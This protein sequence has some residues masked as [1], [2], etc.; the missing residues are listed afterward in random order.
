MASKAQLPTDAREKKHVSGALKF[1]VGDEERAQALK[2]AA[3]WKA[4]FS[5]EAKWKDIVAK[6]G[7]F[8]NEDTMREDSSGTLATATPVVTPFSTNTRAARISSPGAPRFRPI[9][10]LRA[11]TAPPTTPRERFGFPSS[12]PATPYTP[13]PIGNAFASGGVWDN[14]IPRTAGRKASIPPTP[15]TAIAPE[16]WS[17]I[18]PIETEARA[19]YD[20]VKRD[21]NNMALKICANRL[22]THTGLQNKEIALHPNMIKPKDDIH[23]AEIVLASRQLK[24]KK[25][26]DPVLATKLDRLATEEEAIVQQYQVPNPAS[27][28]DIDIWL[29]IDEHTLYFT[30]I[31]DAQRAALLMNRNRRKIHDITLSSA[32][33]HLAWAVRILSDT[34]HVLH[35]KGSGDDSDTDCPT[36]DYTYSYGSF[37]HSL[38]SNSN[39]SLL[40]LTSM[41]DE[42]SHGDLGSLRSTATSSLTLATTAGSRSREASLS[43]KEGRSPTKSLPRAGSV[44]V[45]TSGSPN[46]AAIYIGVLPLRSRKPSVSTPS[47]PQ[48]HETLVRRSNATCRS[49][50]LSILT[51]AAYRDGDSALPSAA[52][53]PEEKVQ[54]RNGPSFSELKDWASELKSMEE[55]GDV[56]RKRGMRV[57]GPLPIGGLERY[58]ALGGRVRGQHGEGEGDQR[59]SKDS[60]YSWRAEDGNAYEDHRRNVSDTS[61]TSRPREE[62]ARPR[63]ACHPTDTGDDTLTPT[64]TLHPRKPSLKH[65]SSSAADEPTASHPHYRTPNQTPLPPPSPHPSPQSRPASRTRS[66]SR[67][68]LGELKRME[69]RERV[70]QEEEREIFAFQ[71]RLKGCWGEGRGRSRKRE[72][73]SGEEG[74]EGGSWRE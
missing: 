46:K 5:E 44:A 68:W 4:R 13:T 67:D 9:H 7:K 63:S 19:A 11:E 47:P 41:L 25:H 22:A 74:T 61:Q 18:K 24:L 16:P 57:V 17:P 36:G 33:L 10:L 48:L 73:G 52:L 71:A 56:L 26:I 49:R 59:R 14:L 60:A 54:R 12:G 69:S 51:N 15:I 66:P 8:A 65:S 21:V 37:L 58:S 20:E 27:L 55:R 2:T 28:L 50:G 70:R 34:Q 64:N 39:E 31:L 35:L 29:Q 30:T 1:V 38:K 53:T 42:R 62:T 23:A 6:I 43:T 45:R 3:M 32:A 72:V 40:D